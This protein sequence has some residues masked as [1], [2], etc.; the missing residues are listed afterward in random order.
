MVKGDDHFV[1]GLG[2]NLGNSAVCKKVPYRAGHGMECIVIAY[3]EV[4]NNILKKAP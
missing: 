1:A 2:V 3:H 4:V